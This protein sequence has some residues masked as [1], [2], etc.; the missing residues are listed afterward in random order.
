MRGAPFTILLHGEAGIGKSTILK[1]L[2]DYFRLLNPVEAIKRPG[3]IPEPLP[4]NG[5][6]NRNS[7]EEYWSCYCNSNWCI[8]YDDLAQRNCK[9]PDFA[10]EIQ[11][12]IYVVNSMPYFPNMASLEEK[13]KVY[14][15]PQL[16]VASTNNK[17]LNAA[18][19]CMKPTAVLRRFPYV[20]QPTVKNEYI[21]DGSTRLDSSKAAGKRDLWDFEIQRVTIDPAGAVTYPV[22]S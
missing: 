6:Y 16:V 17:T 15:A 8:V 22:I 1:T 13:G 2:T 5:L 11:E 20:I 7:G 18:Q 12:L 14:I 3:F 9:V 4:A 19:A 10:A 21:I